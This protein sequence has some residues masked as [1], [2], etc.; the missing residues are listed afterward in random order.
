METLHKKWGFP[1]RIFSVYVTKSAGN[2][3][4]GHI[5]WRKPEW[6]TSFFVQWKS[7]SLDI[8]RKLIECSLK[9]FF[10]KAMFTPTVFEILLFEGRSVLRLAQQVS[11]SERVKFSVENQK[12][13]RLLLE[14]LDK[15]LSYKLRR[16]CMAF[17]VFDFI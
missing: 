7:I 2:C 16:F 17:K 15:W 1:L 11:G 9:N 14:L 8:I 6:K 3:G 4:F 10:A 13:V 5:Y 12:N